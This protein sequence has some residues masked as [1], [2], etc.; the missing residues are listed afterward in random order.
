MKFKSELKKHGYYIFNLSPSNYLIL[1]KGVLVVHFE[2]PSSCQI[3]VAKEWEK[4]ERCYVILAGKNNKKNKN[5][6]EYLK[7]NLLDPSV[8][9]LHNLSFKKKRQEMWQKENRPPL[10]QATDGLD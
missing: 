4:I 8:T 2:D 1:G 5:F 7:K 9:V 6:Y 10:P 3:E